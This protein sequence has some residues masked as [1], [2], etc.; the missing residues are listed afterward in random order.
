MHSPN[1]LLVVSSTWI[2]TLL[3]YLLFWTRASQHWWQPSK[4][5]SCVAYRWGVIFGKFFEN[6]RFSSSCLSYVLYVFAYQKILQWKRQQHLQFCACKLSRSIQPVLFHG[7]LVF[8]ELQ[9]SC[10]KITMY[11]KFNICF[12]LRIYQ[13]WT[14]YVNHWFHHSWL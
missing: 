7:G 3:Y 13:I 5:I 8:I 4:N 14:I 11:I 9:F 6:F 1:L 12:W 2:C 10:M